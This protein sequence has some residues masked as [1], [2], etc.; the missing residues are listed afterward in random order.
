VP[1]YGDA[2][3]GAGFNFSRN[4]GLYLEGNPGLGDNLSLRFGVRAGLKLSF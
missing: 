1:V 3:L 2:V 4:F